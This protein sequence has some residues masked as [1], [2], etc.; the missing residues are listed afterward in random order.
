ML[1]VYGL[2]LRPP[3]YEQYNLIRLVII[4]VADN[5]KTN[6]TQNN[7]NNNNIVI[8]IVKAIAIARRIGIVILLPFKSAPRCVAARCHS[9]FPCCSAMQEIPPA[10]AGQQ[11][12]LV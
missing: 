11:S 1:R 8:R 12:Q 2:G 4:I 9:S 5:N 3:S 6:S 10:H 7:K